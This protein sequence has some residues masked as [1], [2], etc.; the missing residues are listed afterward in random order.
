MASGAAAV[1][2]RRLTLTMRSKEA[3]RTVPPGGVPPAPPG[4][5]IVMGAEGGAEG[6]IA[7][8][9]ARPFTLLFGRERDDVHVP[10]GVNDPAVSRKAGVFTC[11]GQGGER[12]LRKCRDR[13]RERHGVPSGSWTSAEHLPR[14]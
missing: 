2:F 4:A 12:W 10:V 1:R 3:P 5:I 8:P 14:S 9:A 7:V 6:G 13:L 11:T